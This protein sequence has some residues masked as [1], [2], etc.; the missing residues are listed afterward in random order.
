MEETDDQFITVCVGTEFK[1]KLPLYTANKIELLKVTLE[2]GDCGRIEL[3]DGETLSENTLTAFK[4]VIDFLK[5]ERYDLSDINVM[6]EMFKWGVYLNLP[7]EGVF[8]GILLADIRHHDDFNQLDEQQLD[9][10][11]NTISTVFWRRTFGYESDGLGP[12]ETIK[13]KTD[14]KSD[15]PFYKKWMNYQ[16]DRHN[17]TSIIGVGIGVVGLVSVLGYCVFRKR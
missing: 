11:K 1:I 14:A 13:I 16:S 5:S 7:E 8:V 4:N 9:F 17:V 6:F 2:C 3:K 10:M 12:G 15:E